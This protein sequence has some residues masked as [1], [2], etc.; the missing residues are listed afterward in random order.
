[1]HQKLE[2]RIS[3]LRD[4]GGDLATSRKGIMSG[5]Q[6]REKGRGENKGD[7]GQVYPKTMFTKQQMRKIT[8]LKNGEVN[9]TVSFFKLREDL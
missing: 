8:K 2:A 1:V 6:P 3:T 4:L 7:K 9:L 5:G